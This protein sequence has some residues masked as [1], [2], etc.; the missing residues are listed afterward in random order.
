MS[1]VH[2]INIF[3][4][5]VANLHDLKILANNIKVLGKCYVIIA[6]RQTNG[7]DGDEDDHDHDHDYDHYHDHDHYSDDDDDDDTTNNDNEGNCSW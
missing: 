7:D 3:L 2:K 6:D 1:K 4:S 5:C